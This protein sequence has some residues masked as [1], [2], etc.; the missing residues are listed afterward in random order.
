[1]RLDRTPPRTSTATATITAATG[2]PR[3][4]THGRRRRF[5][6]AVTVAIAAALGA[7]LAAC[8]PS[9]D[10]PAQ[11]GATPAATASGA[12]S[13][14]ADPTVSPHEPGATDPAVAAVEE[15]F[16]AYDRIVL[17]G[18]ESAWT[19]RSEPSCEY[20]TLMATFG[21][22]FGSSSG[23]QD[24]G[25][26]TL[27]QIGLA[28][29]DVTI[30]DSG[31]DDAG[32]PVVDVELELL[33]TDDAVLAPEMIAPDGVTDLGLLGREDA[34]GVRRARVHLDR[35]G[36]TWT[37]IR[38]TRIPGD[39]APSAPGRAAPE[40]GPDATAV[41]TPVPPPVMAEHSV[42][43]AVAAV[44]HYLDLERHAYATGDVAEMESL[45]A[46]E[47]AACRARVDVIAQTR[48]AGIELHGGA[49]RVELERRV[50]AEE[51]LDDG[52]VDLDRYR[53]VY[54][55]VLRVTMSDTTVVQ[56][57]AEKTV[58]GQGY[59]LDATLY[60]APDGSWHVFSLSESP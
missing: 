11:G 46:P 39:Q 53:D 4:R 38:I 55:L 8:G 1:M 40:P 47:C 45:S 31:A 33:L 2:R 17:T 23:A 59:H 19:D 60:R 25:A 32:R 57:G 13:D 21:A 41:L 34:D 5:R 35:D 27:A 12:P 28:G 50:S 30:L 51:V 49:S 54:L 43:G 15:F 7:G 6:R 58:P 3:A 24:S 37:V 26:E 22:S 20:C 42:D 10:A 44:Q 18:D 56:D 14:P 29:Y 52:D 16:A 36:E 9:G 48:A